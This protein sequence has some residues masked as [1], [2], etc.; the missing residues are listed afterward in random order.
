MR[1][2]RVVV[3]G[4]SSGSGKTT[5]ACALLAA[6]AG[7]GVRARPFKAGP[8][9]IDP[10]HLSAVSGAA[11]YNLD[12]WLMGAG[13]LLESFARHS[14]LD[15]SVIEGVMGYYDGLGGSSDTASTR[16]VA[17]ITRSPVLLVLDAGGSARSIAATA[18]GFQRFH[19]NSRIAGIILNRIGSKRHEEM[20]RTALAG[21]G[22][23][24]VGA[25]PK[26]AEELGSRHL[27]LVPAG[28]NRAVSGAARRV[29]RS[30]AGHLD[31]DA[32][33]RIMRRA[34]PLPRPAPRRTAR[35]RATIAVALDRSFNFY[36]QENL[37]SL[38]EAG[39]SLRFFSP[40]SAARLPRCDGLY[41]GGGFPE[42]ESAALSRNAAVRRAVRRAA[43]D[44]MPVYAECGGLMYLARGIRDGRGRRPMAG[45]IDADIV[46]TGRPVLGYTSGRIAAG[47]PVSGGRRFR[48]H[49]FHYSRVESLPRDSRLAYELDRGAGISG[50]RD[51]LVM[52]QTLASYGHLCFT[53]GFAGSF[54]GSCARY[55]RR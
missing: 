27:G 39:A 47:T 52:Y 30:L 53:P 5:A 20:C 28:G 43:E 29:A 35:R 14:D 19:R 11:P 7:R 3:A 34:P 8:D 31:V 44:G 37:E 12:V 50:G 54:V 55:S 48:G 15:A 2:P 9:Y 10:G 46:M 36:Y 23:P 22:V 45:L 4:A 13:R 24:V 18:L 42:V 41:I 21:A 49:E 38:Q 32:I 6:L 40:A 1:I 16:H 25:L 33:L 26:G 17:S 51:G